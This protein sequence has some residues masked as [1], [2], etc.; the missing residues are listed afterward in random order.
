MMKR[1]VEKMTVIF[2]TKKTLEPP[3]AADKFIKN[4][5]VYALKEYTFE[6]IIST[7]LSNAL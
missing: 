5:A 4:T 3:K 7:G 2:A 1:K 6:E